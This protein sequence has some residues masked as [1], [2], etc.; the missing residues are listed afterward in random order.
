MAHVYFHPGALVYLCTATTGTD[1]AAELWDGADL[2]A[3]SQIADLEVRTVLAG[4]LRLGKLERGAF[5]AATARWD[6]MRRGMWRVDLSP[7]VTERAARLAETHTL[8]PTDAIH[9]ASAQLLE[10]PALVV[11]GW[12]EQFVTAARAEGCTVLA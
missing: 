11:L 7:Q 9:L 4:G 5:D 1:L 12:G 6:A 3:S 8:R 10:D 2:V